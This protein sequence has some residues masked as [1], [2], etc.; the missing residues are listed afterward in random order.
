[1][2]SSI[3]SAEN[4]SFKYGEETVLENLNFQFIDPS[5]CVLTGPNGA[6]KTTLIRIITGIEK[7][8]SGALEVFGVP[9]NKFV[10]K[11]EL[12]YL[13]QRL[14]QTSLS[15]P[16]TVNDI[17]NSNLFK[18]DDIEWVENIINKLNIKELNNKLISQLSVGQR[19]RVWLARSLIAKPKLI[20]LDEPVSGV[21]NINQAEFYEILENL[22]NLNISII[23][24]SHELEAVAKSANLVWC[25]NRKLIIHKSID[26]FT[27][28]NDFEETYGKNHV[29][30]DHKH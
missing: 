30:L 13:P 3:L 4:L 2:N 17:L 7:N 18:T 1:V 11:G 15:L 12:A 23:L 29:H 28:S 22:F 9:A 16:T 21:D 14:N 24:V 27:H 6:G 5:F 20:I 10:N 8:Y 19:Q 25:L 26:Q